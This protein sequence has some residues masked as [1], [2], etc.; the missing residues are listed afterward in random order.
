MLVIVLL[1]FAAGLALRAAHGESGRGAAVANPPA[2]LKTTGLEASL[3]RLVRA[4]PGALRRAAATRTPD[5]TVAPAGPDAPA[6]APPV[7]PSGAAATPPSAAPAPRPDESAPT[8]TPLGT[9]DTE[10]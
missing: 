3:V 4:D 8:A 7:S 2:P 6:A 9:F 1:A 5:R 10:E